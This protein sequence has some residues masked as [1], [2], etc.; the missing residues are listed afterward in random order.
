[1]N[2]DKIVQYPL[3][4]ERSDWTTQHWEDDVLAVIKQTRRRRFQGR[5]I[6]FF[7]SSSFRYWMRMTEDLGRLDVLNLGF[8]GGT[9][10]S[11]LRYFD[12]LFDGIDPAKIVLYFGENDVA[13]D[14]LTAAQIM[15]GMGQLVKR[16]EE[17][18]GAVPLYYVSIKHS[19]KRWLYGEEFDRLNDALRADADATNNRRF[20]DLTSCL[21]GPNGRPIGR[22]YADDQIHLNATGYNV[23]R[24]RLEATDELW[25]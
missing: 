3:D 8:G 9:V 15:V 13:N 6:V 25:R 18:Y 17:R 1:M 5:P 22:Y 10:E 20:I 23:W 4:V 11:A 7:G 12:R 21:I 24:E 2:Y 16:I 14:G 19:P